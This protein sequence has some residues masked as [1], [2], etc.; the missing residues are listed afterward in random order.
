R[1]A[2]WW[3]RG[4]D[5][6]AVSAVRAPQRSPGRP[7]G[8]APPHGARA[9]LRRARRVQ[10]SERQGD[11]AARLGAVWRPGDGGE[12][13]DDVGRRSGGGGRGGRAHRAAYALPGR[14]PRGD[15]A[16]G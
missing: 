16:G 9:S 6:P 10:G 8:G 13:A 7:G 15:P 5:R 11:R 4:G 14:R 2:W 1:R 3:G 12:G